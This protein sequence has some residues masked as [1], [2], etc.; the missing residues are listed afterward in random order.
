[1]FIVVYYVT[2]PVRKLLGTLSYIPTH[3]T[4]QE[5]EPNNAAQTYCKQIHTYIQYIA[6][7]PKCNDNH[8]TVEYCNVG[9]S[10]FFKDLLLV[11]QK[12]LHNSGASS[13]I[14]RQKKK[15]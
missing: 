12:W 7:M 10:L 3:I 11:I 4:F 8:S 13:T 5:S 9:V 1:V 6:R 14:N 15:N 2:D